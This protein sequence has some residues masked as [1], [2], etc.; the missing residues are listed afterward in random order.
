QAAR[1]TLWEDAAGGAGNKTTAT[2]HR[3]SRSRWRLECP[4][5]GPGAAPVLIRETVTDE[6]ERCSVWDAFTRFRLFSS[7]DGT[8]NYRF[9]YYLFKFAGLLC[10]AAAYVPCPVVEGK[11]LRVVWLAFEGIPAVREALDGLARYEDR[12]LVLGQAPKKRGRPAKTK[13]A[14]KTA[15][16]EKAKAPGKAEKTPVY[17]SGRSVVDLILQGVLNE[18]VKRSYFSQGSVRKQGDEPFRALL[19]LFFQG[20]SIDV[21]S[22][23]LGSLPLAISHWLTVLRLDF[24]AHRYR[25]TL[26][27]SPRGGFGLSMELLLQ[28]PEGT[29]AVPLKDAAKRTGGIEALRA[30]T[31]LSNYLPELREL[32]TKPRVPLAED[33]LV[34]FLDSAADLISR[35]GIQ[36]VFPKNLHRELKPRLVLRAEAKK[37]ASLVRYLDLGSLLDW[38]WEVAIGDQVLSAGEFEA[39]AAQKKALVRF[40]DQ[41]VRLDPAELARLFKQVQTAGAPGAQDFLKAYFAGDSLLSF[42]AEGIIRR[43]FDERD[44]P[45]PEALAAELRPYQKR[46]Y[47]WVCSLL[48]AGFGCVLADDMGLGKTVQSIAVCLRLKSEGLLQGPG[49]VIAPAS[50]LENWER[51]L[52]RFAPS[53]TV[54][55]YHGA[56]RDFRAGADLFLTTYQTAVRDAAKLAEREFSLLIVD[57]AHLLKNAETRGSRTVK[58]L[59][60]QYR[61]ALSGT[62]VENRLEDLRSLFDF[63]LPGY[64]GTAAQ[65]KEQYRYPIEVERR[66]DKAGELKRITAPFLLRRLKTDKS[67]AGDLPEKISKNEYALLEKGQAAL[68]EGIVEGA[69]EKSAETGDGAGRSALILGLLTSLKQVCDHPRVYDKESPAVSALSGKAQLLTLL[70]EEILANR[71]KVLVFSQYV[72]TLE[73]LRTIIRDE[74]GEAAPVYYGGLSQKKR[75]EVID[76]FQTDPACR[77]LLVSLRAGGLG[78]NLT[79]ASRVIHY[80]LW[81]NPAV[82]NQATD[83]AFRIGQRRNVFVHR[84]ITRNSFEEKIDA[85]LQSKR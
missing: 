17:A 12:M 76:L 14:G 29:E 31:A 25:F 58:S 13:T 65:F 45:V 40:R 23:A 3:F 70:L 7:D 59:R 9:L 34:Y 43:L 5:P 42:D 72:E 49:L 6:I 16:L 8:E 71:E 57:E 32:F 78:L 38:H 80:D 1:F 47:N 77:I 61:F 62:P 50:L 19:D 51:E 36:V 2:E 48:A 53:L 56:G 20:D 54:G 66:K 44:Y 33:R 52:A 39:L 37:S 81:Y 64:L 10:A 85:M 27:A 82:E 55:R 67:V 68:Y 41:F 28:G 73:C 84:F 63:V 83:R 35:L 69:L 15:A 22:P 75:N 21:S 18:W 46:G 30:P 60:A 11:R 79:A 26:K 24:S 4:D 74:L